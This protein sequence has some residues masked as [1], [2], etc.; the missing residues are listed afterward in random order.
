V[1]ERVQQVG[2]NACVVVNDERVVMGL[3]RADQLAGDPMHSVEHAMRPGPSTF[4]PNVA[5]TE[6][7]EYMARH[8]LE[9]SPV[10]TS[11]GRLVGLLVRT[12]AERVALEQKPAPLA[13]DERSSAMSDAQPHYREPG[14][15]TRNVFNRAVR[16]LTSAGISV[17]GSRVLEVRGRRSGQPQRIPVNLLTLDGGSYLVSARGEGQWV[18]NVRAADGQLDLLVGRRREHWQARE[19]SDDDKV[20]VLRGY[21]RRWKSEVGV[22]FEGVGP[23]STDEEMRGIA[24]KHPAF[25]LTRR[26]DQ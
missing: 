15:F 18:R 4:R 5:I 25:A 22:F 11:D 14:W 12:D 7:A 13:A 9:S 16:G 19:L 26:T 21:L 23:D 2:W 24:H 20:P 1:S 10:T 6:M 8:N 17:L 3:L